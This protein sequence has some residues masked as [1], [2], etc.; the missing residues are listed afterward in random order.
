MNYTPTKLSYN[1]KSDA[2]EYHV[3]ME[4]YDRSPLDEANLDKNIKCTA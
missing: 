2:F 4:N 1:P 3:L